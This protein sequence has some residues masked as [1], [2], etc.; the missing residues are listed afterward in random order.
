MRKI[1]IFLA[2]GEKDVREDKNEISSFI[3]HLNEKYEDRNLFIK[4]VTDDDI[5]K[6]LKKSSEEDIEKSEIF[7]IIFG[8][9]IKEE[10]INEFNIA[11]NKFKKESNPKIVTFFKKKKLEKES[12]KEFLEKLGGK[13]GHYYNEY[14]HIDSIKLE[15]VEQLDSL[16]FKEIVISTKDGKIYLNDEEI[17]SLDNIPMFFNNEQLTNLKE[18]YKD[19]ENKYW[20]LKRKINIENNIE[21][22]KE[23]EEISNKYIKTKNNIDYLEKKIFS[24][25]QTFVKEA[26]KGILTQKQIYARECL[27]KGNLEEAEKVLDLK[28]IEEDIKSAEELQKKVKDKIKGHI[29]ELI[30][31]ADTYKVDILNPNRHKEIIDSYERAIKAEKENGLPRDTLKIY[32]DYSKEQENY[33]K[34]AELIDLYIKYLKAEELEINPDLY[35]ELEECYS[36]SNQFNKAFEQNSI[37][38]NILKNKFNDLLYVKTKLQYGITC[39][40]LMDRYIHAAKENK[41]LPCSFK[42]MMNYSHEST[43]VLSNL[44]SYYILNKLYYVN[45]TFTYY[46]I[47]TNYHL[48]YCINKYASFYKKRYH[49]FMD[50][51]IRWIEG[52]RFKDR[53]QFKD[54]DEMTMII[55]KNYAEFQ[56]EHKEY[57][58]ALK[59]YEKAFDIIVDIFKDKPEIYINNLIELSDKLDNLYNKYNLYDRKID[60]D[61]KY[62][63]I[64]ENNVISFYQYD[65]EQSEF[66]R[67]TLIINLVNKYSSLIS[68]ET[69]KYT[70]EGEENAIKY[71]QELINELKKSKLSYAKEELAR[72]EELISKHQKRLEVL[73]N[74]EVKGV[75][76][77]Q[78]QIDLGNKYLEENKYQELIQDHSNFINEIVSYKDMLK[79]WDNYRTVEMFNEL[80]NQIVSASIAEKDLKLELTTRENQNKFLEVVENNGH[81]DNIK[82]MIQ[83]LRINPELD[84]A[85]LYYN[86]KAYK[87]A[88]K[89]FKKL[90]QIQNI[91]KKIKYKG[92]KEGDLEQTHECMILNFMALKKYKEAEE[93]KYKTLKD[94]DYL[95]ML[96]N[97]GKGADYN[98]RKIKLSILK[99]TKELY[100]KNSKY[101]ETGEITV[102]VKDDNNEHIK[103]AKVLVTG[104]N[105]HN[106]V[107]FNGYGIDFTKIKLGDY[108][109][110]LTN[111]PDGYDVKETEYQV[112]VDVGEVPEITFKLERIT[113]TISI[114]VV[115]DKNNPM[116]NCVI[117]IYDSEGDYLAEFETNENGICQITTT[118]GTFY[119]KQVK[120][121]PNYVIDDTVY[122]FKVDSDNRTFDTIITNERYKGRVAIQAKDIKGNSIVGLKCGIYD[123]NKELIVNIKTN[124]NGQMGA[125]NLPLGTY[126]YKLEDKKNYVEFQIKEKDEIVIFNIIG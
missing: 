74:V 111:I 8:N 22:E 27:E 50:E 75:K 65:K 67:K 101:E 72:Q 106:E 118:T 100:T 11:Y 81:N 73:K 116:E 25:S 71:H 42:E 23:L 99:N 2:L 108:K 16:G 47:K 126:Y 36:L 123:E 19:L 115:D 117:N 4:L 20:S 57:E 90:E 110:K 58:D 1:N 80:Y 35:L 53:N 83:N 85:L 76:A 119:Y 92:Y 104:E 60:C 94:L 97:D 61:N 52:Y 66:Y 10:A 21:L 122:R 59:Y 107:D 3:G 6:S 112:T 49:Y 62:A 41:S 113:G 56:E 95:I 103:G 32:A 33:E 82:T 70:I 124:E 34:A 39:F 68:I 87:K 17:V 102:S 9:D 18:E 91:F 125:K 114:K 5:S 89:E 120:E 13:L 31:R 55:F 29:Q 86:N 7:F 109:V 98:L 15:V 79:V 51:A 84:L 54:L 78:E 93:L 64:I 12:V 88:E 105:Y 30:L 14:K 46:Y 96:Y 38:E 40:N 24:L 121:I 45:D 28:S 44:V 37:L 48:G 26:G 43:R 77:I 69:V 63:N